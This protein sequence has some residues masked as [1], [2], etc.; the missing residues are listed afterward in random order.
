[1]NY[2]IELLNKIEEECS[3]EQLL[4]A[5][6]HINK[7]YS[8]FTPDVQLWRQLL[9]IFGSKYSELFDE[10]SKY[11]I[12]NKFI[13]TL[14]LKYY[15][16]ERTLKYYISSELRYLED[17]VV[18]EMQS[19]NSR[20]DICRINGSSYAYE[21]KTE[22]DNFKRLEKQINDYSKIFEYIFVVAPVGSLKDLL[23]ILP[24]FCG[25]KTYSNSQEIKLVD[26]RKASKS[27]NISPRLQLINLSTED[28]NTILYKHKITKNIPPSK[29]GRIELLLSKYTAKTINIDFK[30]VLK[31]LYRAN[32]NFIKQNYNDILPIDIQSFFSSTID[33]ALI[34]LHE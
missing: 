27:P 20:V 5:S 13:N 15:P 32:W 12:A 14:L 4:N 33:P 28:I 25:I 21:I 17:T 2:E 18:F 34:Y 31:N 30:N 9:N 29:E 10:Y 1:M 24:D 3:I 16:C 23:D 11:I 8:M 26:S 19:L 6:K 7:Q 22:F